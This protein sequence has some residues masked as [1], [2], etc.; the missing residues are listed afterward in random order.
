MFAR[1]ELA[2]AS[3][4]ISFHDRPRPAEQCGRTIGTS[5]TE[6]T[7]GDLTAYPSQCLANRQKNTGAKRATP[8]C[9]LRVMSPNRPFVETVRE[10]LSWQVVG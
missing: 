2:V 8:D 4:A 5:G 3:V 9:D 10:K 1:D 7:A 6:H